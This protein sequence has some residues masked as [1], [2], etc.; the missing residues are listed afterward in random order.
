MRV[1]A[2]RGQRQHGDLVIN[3]KLGPSPEF[4]RKAAAIVLARKSVPTMPDD[5]WPESVVITIKHT[6]KNGAPMAVE[7]DAKTIK[8]MINAVEYARLAFWEQS[9]Q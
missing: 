4:L 6:G 8:S 9:N 3:N 2:N 7:Y 5:F 1:K